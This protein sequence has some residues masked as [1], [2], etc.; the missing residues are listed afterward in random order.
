MKVVLIDN[1]DSFVYNLAQY[2]GSAGEVPVVMRNDVSVED[3]MNE[4][5]DALVISPGPGRP[6]KA[7]CSVEVVRR[8]GPRTPL[9]GVC[10]GHQAIGVS[11]GSK[12]VRADR[13]F[14]GKTSQIEHS[15][16]G[17]F[18]GL[19]PFFEATRYHSLVIDPD[20]VP[21]SLE[22]TA[23]TKDG[24][25]MGVRHAIDPV[26][27]VQFHPESVLTKQGLKLIENFLASARDWNASPRP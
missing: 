5:P 20:S 23:R 12:V 25:V 26:E 21:A 24:V 16:V 2:I 10:L 27:G 19:E 11:Y 7:G 8:L 9:L 14:H 13:L 3:V 17:V 4:K 1:F 15:E 6:E 18:R 22:I